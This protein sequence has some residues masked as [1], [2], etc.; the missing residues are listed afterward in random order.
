MRICQR[1]GE[2]CKRTRGKVSVSVNAFRV[3]FRMVLLWL[4][5]FS[6]NKE[7][8]VDGMI[9]DLEAAS[10]D[11]APFSMRIGTVELYVSPATVVGA[12]DAVGDI[13]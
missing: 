12:K 5:R 10:T 2:S 11:V 4:T 6:G 3:I 1:A 9:K 13:G 7:W 8:P